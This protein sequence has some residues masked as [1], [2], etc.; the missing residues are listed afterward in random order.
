MGVAKVIMVTALGANQ[1]AKSQY[2]RTKWLAEEILRSSGL[3]CLFIRPSLLIGKTFG[4]RDSKLVNRFRE[5]IKTRKTVPLIGGG[6]NQIQPLFIGDAVSA[7]TKCVISDQAA[8][9]SMAPTLELGGPEIMTM[10]QFIEELMKV[11]ACRRAFLDIPPPVA[12]AVAWLAEI[13]QEVPII[14]RDQVKLS[15]EDNV[16]SENAIITKLGITPTRV[17]EALKTYSNPTNDFAMCR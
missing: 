2:H 1:E 3:K 15:T 6:C 11:M 13:L 4:Q 12:M 14:S 16:C 9:G 17:A 8:S 5:L 7:I 10:R